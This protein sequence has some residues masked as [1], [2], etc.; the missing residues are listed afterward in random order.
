MLVFDD[1]FWFLNENLFKSKQ[2]TNFME[3]SSVFIDSGFVKTC[4]ELV[5]GLVESGYFLVL[6][7]TGKLKRIA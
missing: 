2:T 4:D 7:T 5:I 3:K 6:F 1:L